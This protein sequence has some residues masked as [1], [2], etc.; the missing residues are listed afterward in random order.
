MLGSWLCVEGA[1]CSMEAGISSKRGE[2]KSPHNKSN[3]CGVVVVWV[4][5]FVV[6]CESSYL[7]GGG[8][9]RLRLKCKKLI[10]FLFFVKD[11]PE[12]SS[13]RR[14]AQTIYPIEQGKYQIQIKYPFGQFF[15]KNKQFISRIH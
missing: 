4:F 2:K 7:I 3:L 1:A 11:L 9:E 10:R 5:R 6:V 12:S 13:F 8:R 15:F 14:L